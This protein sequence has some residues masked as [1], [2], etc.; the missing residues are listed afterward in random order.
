M[1]KSDEYLFVENPDIRAEDVAALREAI[2]WEAR[3]ERL[4]KIIGNIYFSAGCFHMGKLVGYV[5]VVSD[6]VDDAY[7]RNLIV[8]PEHQ[9]RG[10]GSELLSMALLRIK[11][12]GIKMASLI[13]EPRLSGFYQKRGFTI[14]AAG[15]I[16]NEA[17]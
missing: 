14:V 15:I 5:G 16:D 17:D 10:I 9:G 11:S 7:I 12:D 6:A 4:R 8:H 13:F 3:V 2:G 1:T